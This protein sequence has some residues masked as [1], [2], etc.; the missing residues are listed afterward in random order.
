[1]FDYDGGN[2]SET[3][4]SVTGAAAGD[5]LGL[6]NSGVAATSDGAVV[7]AGVPQ[8]YPY[9]GSGAGTGR[10]HVFTH[11]GGWSQQIL[12]PSGVSTR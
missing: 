8:G 1:M 12:A 11:N 9:G 5:R 10:V 6:G 3:K 7:V 4:L 2:W